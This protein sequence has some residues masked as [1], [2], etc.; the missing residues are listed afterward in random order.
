MI[1]DCYDRSKLY[2]FGGRY[3]YEEYPISG[4]VEKIG[5]DDPR[6]TFSVVDGL[7]DGE[8]VEYYQNGRRMM[9]QEYSEGIKEGLYVYYRENGSVSDSFYYVKDR[10]DGEILGYFESG[11]E[12]SWEYYEDGLSERFSI[13]FLDTSKSTYLWGGR[14][15]GINKGDWYYKFENDSCFIRTYENNNEYYDTYC[16]CEEALYPPIDEW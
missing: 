16:S 6:A 9:S 14:V 12:R 11:S 15:N 7:M 2:V 3:Y 1:G 13:L 8:Y 4:C 5:D 10:P